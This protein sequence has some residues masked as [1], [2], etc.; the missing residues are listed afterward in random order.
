MLLTT[1]APEPEVTLSSALI[2]EA[3]A[4]GISLEYLDSLPPFAMKILQ[5]GFDSGDF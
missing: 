5:A 4:E 3:L 1:T 2:D